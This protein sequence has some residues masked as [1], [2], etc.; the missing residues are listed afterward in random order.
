MAASET[1]M[2]K[3]AIL[4]PTVAKLANVIA[5]PIMIEDTYPQGSAPSGY[6]CRPPTGVIKP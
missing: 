4:A 1:P 6:D 3:D 2:K 5:P